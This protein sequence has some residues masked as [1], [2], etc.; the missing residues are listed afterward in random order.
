MTVPKRTRSFI[1]QNGGQRETQQQRRQ[2]TQGNREGRGIE[3]AAESTTSTSL[4]PL[5]PVRPPPVSGP[6]P[7]LPLS[8]YKTP[9]KP[10]ISTQ[11][12]T[13]PLALSRDPKRPSVGGLLPQSEKE[14]YC[15]EKPGRNN[16]RTRC[17][18]PMPERTA[19]TQCHD[20]TSGH[21][22]QCQN[23]K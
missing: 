14:D 9:Q 23:A 19:R 11:T 16:D 10:R 21:R 4:L 5:P 2:R 13:G 22:T 12:A 15:Q 18:E 20:T 6:G 3:R 1:K 8:P 7:T 17:L